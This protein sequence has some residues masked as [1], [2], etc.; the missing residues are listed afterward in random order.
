[1]KNSMT[2]KEKEQFSRALESF[3]EEFQKIIKKSFK[4]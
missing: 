3:N 2:E 4:C 1:M